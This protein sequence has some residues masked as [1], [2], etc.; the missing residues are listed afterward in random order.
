MVWLRDRLPPDAVICN[1]AGNFSIWI[2]RYYRFRGFGSQLAP[3]SGSMGYGVPA[4]V[5]AKRQHPDRIGSP[6]RAT[7]TS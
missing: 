4:A 2:H 5:M 6:S 1:G 3:T 7:A